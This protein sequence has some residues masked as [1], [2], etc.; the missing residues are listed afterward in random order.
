MCFKKPK[1]TIYTMPYNQRVVNYNYEKQSAL[2]VATTPE[3]CDKII[4]YLRKK[5][6]I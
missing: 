2:S 6:G 3:E 4:R 1:H 5:W